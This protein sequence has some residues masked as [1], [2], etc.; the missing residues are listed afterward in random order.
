MTDEPRPNAVLEVT[1]ELVD[2][3]VAFIR[4][5]LDEM[6]QR[7]KAVAR[8]LAGFDRPAAP[9]RAPLDPLREFALS[10]SPQ[11]ELADA[12]ATRRLLD[13]LLF[14]NELWITAVTRDLE[15][16]IALASRWRLHPD[17]QALLRRHARPIDNAPAAHPS[18]EGAAGA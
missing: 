10:H 15:A 1:R 7:A 13:H 6:E 9:D 8:L 18:N 12:A 4:A 11:H 2:D 16:L 14:M 3:V 17:F 5:R